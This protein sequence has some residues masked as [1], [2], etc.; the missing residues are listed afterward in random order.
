LRVGV[1]PAYLSKIERG[2]PL[3]SEQ[4][5]VKQAELLGDDKD[6]LLA[7]GGKMST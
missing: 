2:G 3:P 7:L 4:V 6:V 5:I 1:D